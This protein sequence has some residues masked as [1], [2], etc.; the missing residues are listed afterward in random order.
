M[1]QNRSLVQGFAF[2]LFTLTH[3]LKHEHVLE[4]RQIC[5]ESIKRVVRLN[6]TKDKLANALS[7]AAF[8]EPPA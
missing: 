6:M 2:F 5:R 1:V 3:D 4:L 7:E 8:G